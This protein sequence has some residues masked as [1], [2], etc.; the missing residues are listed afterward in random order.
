MQCKSWTVPAK[1]RLPGWANGLRR[2]GRRA[3]AVRRLITSRGCHWYP[4]ERGCVGARCS[5][6]IGRRSPLPA[7]RQTAWKARGADIACHGQQNSCG[8]SCEKRRDIILNTV[9]DLSQTASPPLCDAK[10]CARL[11]SSSSKRQPV[12][13]LAPSAVKPDAVNSWE[14]IPGPRPRRHRLRPLKPVG[15]VRPFQ[16]AM[17]RSVSVGNHNRKKIAESTGLWSASP[18][19]WRMR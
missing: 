16:E 11:L 14:P 2:P 5:V 13:L 7:Q 1:R 3:R 8:Y 18:P 17:K 12:Y 15:C 10:A 19:K 9:N 4:S 6:E